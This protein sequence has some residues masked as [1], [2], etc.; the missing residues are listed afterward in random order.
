VYGA[1]AL[2]QRWGAPGD[3][4][5]ALRQWNNF[6]PEI[7]QVN[8]LVAQYKSTPQTTVTA[9]PGSPPAPAGSAATGGV[10]QPSAVS[11]VNGLSGVKVG[12]AIVSAG[13]QVLAQD[14]DTAQV[15]GA[16]ITKAMLLV[17]YLDKVGSAPVNPTAAA[18]LQAMIE[19]S[20]NPDGSWVF[21]QVG[22]RAVHQ[23]AAAAGMTG[24][25]LDTSDPAYTLGQSRVTALDFARFF[26]RV[27]QLMPAANRG[28]G[29]ALLENISASDHWGILNA[30]VGVGASKAGWKPEPGAGWV[31]NQA[32]QLRLQGQTAG[33]AVVS[34][35]SSSLAAG[36]QI[37]QTVASDLLASASQ[38]T[39]TP[40]SASQCGAVSGPTVPGAVAQIEP[41]G[42]AAIPAGAPQQ[43]QEAIAAGN[44]IIHTF[45]S[46]ER[47]A[48]MLTQVQDSYDC[49]GSTDFVL[50][51][52][53]L[54]SP[55]V[56]VGAGTASDSSMLETY[57]QGGPGQWITVYANPGHAFIQ[58]AGLVLDTAYY[59]SVQPASVPDSYPPDDP[60]NGGPASGPRWQPASIIAAQVHGDANGWFDERHPAGL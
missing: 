60:A 32:G 20:S 35:G 4:Q 42:T 9:T 30:G 26:A 33:I 16:S 36:E 29:M 2:L 12:F 46:Q 13:G 19:Q 50:Y 41:D 57:G 14:N 27:D 24:F 11:Y 21:A 7:N 44:A 5:G 39:A 43:V 45:Y 3:W 10:D 34:D 18:H 23:V 51:N 56:D 17:A 58:V 55:Q 59:S 40:S 22:A 54:N 53:G 38:P 47:R 31:V 48:N 6:A 52:A 15:P 1:A 49:S 28:Y 37:M 25:V 8:Q